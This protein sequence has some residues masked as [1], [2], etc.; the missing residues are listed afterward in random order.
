[1][2]RYESKRDRFHRLAEDRTNAVLDKIRILAN[3]ANTAT[4]EYDESEVRAIFN[5]IES[6]LKLARSQ[7]RT[8][9]T[10][11]KLPRKQRNV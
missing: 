10:K 4:Y 8:G 6:E 11:F 2:P 3:C 7:F 1:M 9:V 5:V